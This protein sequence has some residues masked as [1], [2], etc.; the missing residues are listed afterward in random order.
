MNQEEPGR[1]QHYRRPTNTRASEDKDY[2]SKK[3]AIT[4]TILI[5]L[6][7]ALIP[8]AY[9][10]ARNQ[11]EQKAAE[12]E[13]LTKTPAKQTSKQVRKVKKKNKVIKAKKKTALTASSK[14][15]VVKKG[16]TLSSI[17]ARHGLSVAKIA[18]INH[19]PKTKEVEIGESLRL[20]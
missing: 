12:V 2:Y 5:L 10:L 14:F 17:A 19:L 16:D 8:T 20:R 13:R 4:M 9:G 11:H 18:K 7:L 3:W 1:Y 6:L 15:Y